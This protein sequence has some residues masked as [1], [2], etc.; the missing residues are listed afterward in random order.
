MKPVEKRGA[1]HH[2]DELGEAIDDLCADFITA[3]FHFLLQYRLH[4][5]D[6]SG[7]DFEF[8]RA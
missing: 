7:N 1:T 3:A 5:I 2:W 4:S 8:A 6:M